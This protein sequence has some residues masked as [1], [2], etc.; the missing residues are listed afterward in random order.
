[1]RAGEKI[2]FNSFEFKRPGF[3]I[4]SEEFE[5]FIEKNLINDIKAGQPLT[6]DFI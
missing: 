5:I 4:T 3:G 1:M 6:Y 2:E